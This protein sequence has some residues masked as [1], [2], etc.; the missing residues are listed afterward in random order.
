[1]NKIFLC[2]ITLSVT[3]LNCQAVEQLVLSDV[4]KEA[5]DMQMQKQISSK[6]QTAEDMKK[7]CS[8]VGTKAEEKCTNI[9]Q[10]EVK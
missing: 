1:M 4:I 7:S 10:N 9:S 5:R 8:D 3:A 6:T 2:L